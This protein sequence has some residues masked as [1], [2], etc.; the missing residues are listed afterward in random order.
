MLADRVASREGARRH[1]AAFQRMRV[2]AAATS[3]VSECG[4]AGLS[5]TTVVARAGVSRQTF[6][7]VFD[8]R[9]DCLLAVIEQTF[10]QIAARA[11]QDYE[12]Y[13]GWP[14]RL[15][16]GLARVLTCLEHEQTGELALAYL[17][18]YGSTRADLRTQ[19]LQELHVLVDRGCE[20][21]SPRLAPSPL[22]GEFV[23]GSVLAAVHAQM[24]D[25]D[26]PQLVALLNTL[27]WMIALPYLGPG[28]AAKE[29]TRAAPKRSEP[30]P[31]VASEQLQRLDLRLTYRTARVL[32]AIS[33]LPGSSNAAIAEHASITDPGQISKLLARLLRV[34]LVENRGAGCG[35]G[36]P[37]AWWLTDAGV[38]L[39]ATLKRRVVAVPRRGQARGRATHAGERD[40]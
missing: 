7:D 23:V 17:L 28:A 14:A 22:T 36:A 37:N 25:P 1:V 10:D 31:R 6:Y 8:S 33:L 30:P 40:A 39:A 2:L 19:V 26:A 5:V 18:G 11:R 4:S 24:Q 12:Q 29:L 9:E 32:E 38:Q 20:H 34:R 13:E 3:V 21:A 15:R 35:A 16:A 27:M